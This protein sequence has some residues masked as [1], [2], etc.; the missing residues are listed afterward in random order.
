MSTDKPIWHA[1]GT[2]KEQAGPGAFAA[3]RAIEECQG[4]YHQQLLDSAR[5]FT[6]RELISFSWG[7]GM[8]YV[9]MQPITRLTENLVLSVGDSMTSS[10]G[11]NKVKPTPVTR[12]ASFKTR[13]AA[14]G[15]DKFLYGEFRRTD[16]WHL[17]KNAYRDS[18]WAGV[19]TLHGYWEKKGK[20][21]TLCLERVFPDELVID[22]MECAFTSKP[23][24]VYRRRVMPAAELAARFEGFDP[25]LDK[26]S[27]ISSNNYNRSPAQG[28]VVVVEA[29]RLPCHG[30]P[31]RHTIGTENQTLEDEE[32]KHPWL[33]YV[34]YHWQEPLSGFYPPS[35]VE[36]VIPYQLDLNRVNLV[37]RDGQDLM[38]RP[39]LWVPPGAK[40]TL[41]QVDNRIGKVLVSA[42]QP[43]PMVWPGAGPELYSERDR[44]VRTCFEY[45]GLTQLSSQGKLPQGA[46][47]DSAGTTASRT[48]ASPT[49]PSGSSGS[50]STSPTC[51]STWPR[52]LTPAGPA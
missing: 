29:Y 17:A 45:F 25:E 30:V 3:C 23:R 35:G 7:W 42:V 38:V 12:G 9:S 5:L 49:A 28:Y 22:Q 36:Q 10:I 20:E 15:L 1:Q 48:S 26:P 24:T 37:I 33:P 32:W 51:S 14:K 8:D 43:V 41:S 21:A 18:Y 11:K 16:A 40:V 2:P 19:G 52:T 47:L 27:Y 4:E 6:N 50:S 31:G 44:I 34:F 39:R 46:R 13:R